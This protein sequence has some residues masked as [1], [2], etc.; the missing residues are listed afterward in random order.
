[1]H[2]NILP[3]RPAGKPDQG[4]PIHAS[5]PTEHNAY[6]T[7]GGPGW[8]GQ[9]RRRPVRAPSYSLWLHPESPSA[10]RPQDWWKRDG[11]SRD[12]QRLGPVASFRWQVL[13]MGPRSVILIVETQKTF[14]LRL[15][16][17]RGLVIQVFQGGFRFCFGALTGPCVCCVELVGTP[18]GPAVHA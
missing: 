17:L 16:G 10:E 6:R 15:N 1:M 11:R 5:V 12:C 13:R 8:A 4:A 3:S 9:A 18:V 14:A 2:S 7:A